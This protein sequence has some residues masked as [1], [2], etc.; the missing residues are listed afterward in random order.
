MGFTSRWFTGSGDETCGSFKEYEE[1]IGAVGRESNE[2]NYD[3][4]IA[5]LDAA[6]PEYAAHMR[7]VAPVRGSFW[8]SVMHCWENEEE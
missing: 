1:A 6:N 8:K 3:A 5:A 7:N 4:N 2:D